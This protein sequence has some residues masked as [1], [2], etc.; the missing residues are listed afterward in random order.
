MRLLT[1]IDDGALAGRE[2]EQKGER[3]T[4]SAEVQNA[5]QW[6]GR[7]ALCQLSFDVD[8]WVTV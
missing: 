7:L 3:G 4:K 2:E 1:K 5:G 8:H 6:V